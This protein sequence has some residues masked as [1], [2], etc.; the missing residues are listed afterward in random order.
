MVTTASKS[1]G[2]SA[3]LPVPFQSPFGSCCP[4]LN[5]GLPSLLHD[6]LKSGLI[7][8]RYFGA[9]HQG[10]LNTCALCPWLSVFFALVQTISLHNKARLLYYAD[11]GGVKGILQ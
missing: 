4:S 7:S 1:G 10:P 8:D 9:G 11:G 3:D 5:R 6:N 2:W